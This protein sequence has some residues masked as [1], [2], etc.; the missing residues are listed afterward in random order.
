M[1]SEELI[2]AINM[3]KY[4]NGYE[5]EQI[6]YI[7]A[8]EQNIENA[9]FDQMIIKDKMEQRILDMLNYKNPNKPV[10]KKLDLT[11]INQC[12]EEVREALNNIDDDEEIEPTKQDWSKIPF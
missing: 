11:E 9:K 7:R 8:M 1:T 2:K 12:I 4:P 3:M 6:C 10:S 5:W